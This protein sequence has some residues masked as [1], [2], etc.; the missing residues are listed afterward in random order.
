MTDGP[1]PDPF[2]PTSEEI[3][4]LSSLFTYVYCA[5]CNVIVLKTGVMA[6]QKDFW[7]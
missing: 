5:Y 6:S 1:L 7:T 3:T 2:L 4:V